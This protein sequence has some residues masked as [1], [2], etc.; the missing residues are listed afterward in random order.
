MR[1]FD[2]RDAE[3]R[4]E[5]EREYMEDVMDDEER[6]GVELPDLAACIPPSLKAEPL[7]DREVSRVLRT[8]SDP[9]VTALMH[10]VRR[11][12]RC[13]EREER[14]RYWCEELNDYD[15]AY[16]LPA[17]LLVT[18]QHDEIEGL[19][20]Q[21]TEELYNW[22]VPQAPN[23]IFVMDPADPDSVA[24]AFHSLGVLCDTAAEASRL[25]TMLETIAAT[26]KRP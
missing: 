4:L 10:A 18:E 1:V 11:L 5:R 19:Y 16:P 25:I 13:A 2:Y 8:S 14:P 15:L 26:E 3:E 6:A 17:L 7:R 20:D 9:T 24:S 12:R 23:A 21:E 22:G